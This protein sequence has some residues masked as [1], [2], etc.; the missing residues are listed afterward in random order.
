[1]LSVN[2]L[3]A[4][5]VSGNN[6]RAGHQEQIWSELSCAGRCLAGFLL[7]FPDRPHRRERLIDLFWPE[8]EAERGR[9][10]LKSAIWRLR[11]MLAGSPDY[12]EGQVL[13]TVGSDTVLERTSWLDVDTWA[14][15][16]AA[17]AALKGTQT[18]LESPEKGGS[19]SSRG[20]LWQKSICHLRELIS[21]KSV[22]R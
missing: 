22:R 16:R 7:T 19:K 9:R 8:L 11:R 2:L 6:E 3:G 4:S 14:L 18:R 1:V 15:L 20:E 5:R 12:R 17:S 21:P 13:R 10:A